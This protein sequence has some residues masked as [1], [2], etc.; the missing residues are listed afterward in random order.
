MAIALPLYPPPSR[1]NIRLVTARAELKP[2]FGGDTQRINRMGARYSGVFDLP[3]QTY[4][5]AQDW[6]DIDDEEATVTFPVLQ[7]GLDTGAPGVPRVNGGS[8]AGSSLILDGLTPQYVLR[9]N[10]FLSVSTGG[11][12]YL[13]RVKTETIANSSGQ[14]TVPLRTMLRTSPADNDVVEIAQPL[15]EGFCIPADGCWQTDST[16]LVYLSFTIEERG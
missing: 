16:H 2:A 1:M 12:L 4:V 9:K 15:I 5:D 3:P 8:Q 13:Y 6:A 11:R 10:Q 7:P 14:A